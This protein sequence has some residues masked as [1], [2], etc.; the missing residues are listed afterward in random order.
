MGLHSG[1][2][3]TNDGSRGW[4]SREDRE[5]QD[6]RGNGE[7]GRTVPVRALGRR[8]RRGMSSGASE[9]RGLEWR[10]DNEELWRMSGMVRQPW[11][12]WWGGEGGSG[13]A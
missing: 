5:A 11:R 7:E 13:V 3:A 6:R 10:K 12:S 2:P 9:G 8:E 4:S 1:V